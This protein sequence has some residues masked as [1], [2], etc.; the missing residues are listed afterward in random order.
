METYRRSHDSMTFLVVARYMSLRLEKLYSHDSL[1]I[2]SQPDHQN[3]LLTFVK[4]NKISVSASPLIAGE[5]QV[6]YIILVG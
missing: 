6:T 5:H 4:N 3:G 1:T 2:V